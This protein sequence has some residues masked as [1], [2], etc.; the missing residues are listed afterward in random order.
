MAAAQAGVTYTV[1]SRWIRRYK[2]HANVADALRRGLSALLPE[3][4]YGSSLQL[5][6]DSKA[7][8]AKH[9]PR[10][11]VSQGITCYLVSVP[12]LLRGIKRAAQSRDIKLAAVRGS[13][14]KSLQHVRVAKRLKSCR[15]NKT[16]N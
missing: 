15:Q 5:L 1:A 12:T 8:S 11:A 14:R 16:T 6:L 10:M 13:S 9:V 4:V 7:V 3:G 2:Q